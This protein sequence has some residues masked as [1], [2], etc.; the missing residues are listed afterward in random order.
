MYHPNVVAPQVRP[1]MLSST[2]Q[3]EFK[4]NGTGVITDDRY[5]RP[6]KLILYKTKNKILKTK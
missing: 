2:L 1:Q 6:S 3:P 5:K 4:I